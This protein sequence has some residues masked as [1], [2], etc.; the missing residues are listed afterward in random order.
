[1]TSSGK[2]PP[3]AR[4]KTLKYFFFTISNQKIKKVHTRTHTH[5][6]TL[7][8]IHP[9]FLLRSSPFPPP[10]RNATQQTPLSSERM[11]EIIAATGMTPGEF[12]EIADLDIN[13]L[14]TANKQ[15]LLDAE[16]ERVR[17][18]L[19]ANEAAIER[20]RERALARTSAP[21]PTNKPSPDEWR[22]YAPEAPPIRPSAAA[23]A[24]KAEEKKEALEAAA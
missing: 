16:N 3:S 9:L 19:V 14:Y 10:Q 20:A 13:D 6:H 17:A 22:Y 7:T 18:K 2:K 23:V 15:R 11:A 4:Q 21:T 1:M 24:E 12:A 8:L 5:A